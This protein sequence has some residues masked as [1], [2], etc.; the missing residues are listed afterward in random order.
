MGRT[1]RVPEVFRFAGWAWN[2]DLAWSVVTE[3]SNEILE[4]PVRE[5]AKAINT[6]F[7]F[8]V[9]EERAKEADLDRPLLAIQFLAED[10][11]DDFPLVIDGW[12]RIYKAVYLEDRDILPLI[13]LTDEQERYVRDPRSAEFPR[14]RRKRLRQKRYAFLQDVA[15]SLAVRSSDAMNISVETEDESNPDSE[16]ILYIEHHQHGNYV[17]RA[18]ETH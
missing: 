3:E 10:P 13:M 8:Q 15:F 6:P 18:E 2:V 16:P 1:E 7:G 17:L 5:L 12:H 4:T 11:N 14:E 9:D